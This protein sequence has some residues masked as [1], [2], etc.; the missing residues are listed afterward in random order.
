MGKQ[1]CALQIGHPLARTHARMHTRTH[2]H[3]HTHTHARTLTHKRADMHTH[4]HTHAHKHA[5][6]HTGT[7]KSLHSGLT[8]A[9][10]QPSGMCRCVQDAI[11][12][13]QASG[14]HPCAFDK[15]F[16]NMP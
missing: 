1:S 14:L 4:I 5:H 16:L 12:S 8:A 13:A 2:K 7:S 9:S 6:A 15:Y 10:L 11:A 3:I